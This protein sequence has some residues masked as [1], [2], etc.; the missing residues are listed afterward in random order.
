[1]D[2]VIIDLINNDTIYMV[3]FDDLFTQDSNPIDRFHEV[4]EKRPCEC[5]E[6]ES[7]SIVD[8]D[9]LGS[10]KSPL[11]WVCLECDALYLK[12][13]LEVTLDV[14]TVAA[15][16]WTNPNDWGWRDKDEFN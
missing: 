10:D 16:T 11:F 12:Y 15:G 1:V 4:D 6:C 14:L 3:F 2:K 7:R 5:S 13:S 9:V 8:L